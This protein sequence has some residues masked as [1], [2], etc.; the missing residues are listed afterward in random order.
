MNI[1]FNY[2]D[3]DFTDDCAE[4]GVSTGK[5]QENSEFYHVVGG[6]VRKFSDRGRTSFYIDYQKGKKVLNDSDEDQLRTLEAIPDTAEELRG[7]EVSA[8]GIGVVQYLDAASMAIYLGYKH[9]EIDFD[10]IGADGPVAA[11]TFEEFDVIMGGG[12]IKF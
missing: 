2:G 6:L 7:S 5:C 10:L 11:K 8:W 4:P 9:F 1:A 3:R 12:I